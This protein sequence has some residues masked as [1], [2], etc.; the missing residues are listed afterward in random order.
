[1]VM[2]APEDPPQD[3]EIEVST[4]GPGIGESIVVH[5]GFGEW[6]VVDSCRDYVTRT[7]AALN[8]FRQIGVDPAT[9][10][11][12]IVASHWDSDHIR[13]L[14]DLVEACPEA[15]FWCTAAVG[16]EEFDT[17]LDIVDSRGDDLGLRLRELARVI[18]RRRDRLGE[19]HGTPSLAMESTMIL[20]RPPWEGVP[21]RAIHALSPSPR[22][23]L[24]TTAN[25]RYAI[26]DGQQLAGRVQR[27]SR[28]DTS[29]AL[30]V[31][32]GDDGALL[33][34]DLE[35]SAD[36]TRG[37]RPAVRRLRELGVTASLVKIPHHG[38]ANAH[39]EEMWG[40][41]LCSNPG[42]AVTPFFSGSTPL[43]RPGDRA[44][45]RQM[46]SQGYLTTDRPV[47]AQGVTLLPFALPPGGS[48]NSIEGK[49]GHIR[50]RRKLDGS[51]AWQVA[52]DDCARCV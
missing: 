33:G 28:N 27:L 41:G 15:G 47:P 3:D 20:E 51:D 4:F 17:L 37:W 12:S 45:I 30:L 13:A 34:G 31:A 29:V 50:W 16:S 40:L 1:M 23:M 46:T 7:A 6:V 49:V 24:M 22:A 18:G 52:L 32:F 44:R 43:P 5:L 35:F 38:S 19:G 14:G 9:S 10:V 48:L 42:A 2:P 11:R 39:D 8:Y 21:R 25:A 26:S 36:T